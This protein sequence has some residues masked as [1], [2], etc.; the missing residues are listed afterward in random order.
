MKNI[1]IK[2]DNVGK[3]PFTL[4]SNTHIFIKILKNIIKNLFIRKPLE[5]NL[6]VCLHSVKNNSRNCYFFKLRY[7][8][9]NIGKILYHNGLFIKSN[10]PINSI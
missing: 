7:I 5:K 3:K 1:A 10:S 4:S 6:G 9:N 2:N 8:F